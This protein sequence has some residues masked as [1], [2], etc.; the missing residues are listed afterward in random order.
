MNE[1]PRR[2][3]VVDDAIAFLQGRGFAGCSFVSSIPD[4]SETGM[5]FDKWSRWFADTARLLVDKTPQDGL[6]VLTQTDIRKDGRWIDKGFMVQRAVEDT[7][8]VLIARK[9]VVRRPQGSV[10]S[11]R[12][13]FT[14]LLCF[15]KGITIDGARPDT[16]PDVF[17][18]GAISWT[19]GLGERAC[20]ACVDLV[21]RYAQAS[22]TIVDPFCGEGMVLAAANHRGLHAIGCERN[23]K[24]ARTSARMVIKQARDDGDGAADDDA[25]AG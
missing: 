9:V 20:L 21:A 10:S 1:A 18:G 15:S 17:E 12:A 22:T 16:V 11:A 7:G 25:A 6:L 4:V 3:V 2:E 24:R 19:R 14:H 5:S 23:S 13:A 8:A